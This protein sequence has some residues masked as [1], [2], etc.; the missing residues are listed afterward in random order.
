V[1]GIELSLVLVKEN[2]LGSFLRRRQVLEARH[3]K[4]RNTRQQPGIDRYYYYYYYYYYYGTTAGD[5]ICRKKSLI[6]MPRQQQGFARSSTVF[7]S[8]SIRAR[9]H[10]ALPRAQSTGLPLS[11]STTKPTDSQRPGEFVQRGALFRP[12][13]GM[14]R[15]GAGI[16]DPALCTAYDPGGPLR[17]PETLLR[18]RSLPWSH[19]LHLGSLHRV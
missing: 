1:G 8:E 10:A 17:W 19:W 9:P 2:Q 7:V 13:L 15:T 6:Y 12:S 11:A 4:V 3:N 14:H 18:N 16:P 5:R